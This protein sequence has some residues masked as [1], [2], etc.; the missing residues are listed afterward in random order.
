M[1]N[2]NTNQP[3]YNPS[4]IQMQPNFASGTGMF[5]NQP[6]NMT[7]MAPPKKPKSSTTSRIPSLFLPAILLLAFTWILHTLA[8]F[9]PY[10]ST[11]SQISGSRAGLWSAQNFN[12]TSIQNF[13]FPEPNTFQNITG[14][15]RFTSANTKGYL[16]TVQFLM[17][18]NFCLMFI[19]LVLLIA[20]YILSRNSTGESRSFLI[21]D[22]NTHDTVI[23]YGL[24]LYIIYVFGVFEF[25]AWITFVG[26][27]HDNNWNLNVSFAFAIIVSVF[28]IFIFIMYVIEFIKRFKK[29][30][31]T[32]AYWYGPYI[33]WGFFVYLSALLL[34]LL[35][36]CCPEWAYKKYYPLEVFAEIG[37]F[38]QCY[39]SSIYKKSATQGY[40]TLSNSQSNQSWVNAA[41]AFM[42]MA[43]I[44][45]M[46]IL[47]VI[48]I[49][50]KEFRHQENGYFAERVKQPT[51]T[52]IIAGLI[53]FFCFIFSL[54]G[55]SVFG[56]EVF[57]H[58]INVNWAYVVAVFAMV[59]FLITGILFILDGVH[60]KKQIPKVNSSP[61]RKFFL[62]APLNY[63]V[64]DI[65]PVPLPAP[66]GKSKSKSKSK[67]KPPEPLQFTHI[68][69]SSWQS[70]SPV[71]PA[72]S[73]QFGQIPPSSWQTMS[74][75]DFQQQTMYPTSDFANTPYISPQEMSMMSPNYNM[76][77][78]PSAPLTQALLVEYYRQMQ[79]NP[80]LSSLPY[81]EGFMNYSY[82]PLTFSNDGNYLSDEDRLNEMIVQHSLQQQRLTENHDRLL[83]RY[84][85][86]MPPRRSAF[87][88]STLP[89]RN[90]DEY[91][92]R[93]YGNDY[94]NTSAAMSRAGIGSSDETYRWMGD[95]YDDTFPRD[96][97]A[98]M[99]Y[100]R[101]ESMPYV[102]AEKVEPVKMYDHPMFRSTLAYIR[103]LY[104]KIR[105]SKKNN[106]ENEVKSNNVDH[107]EQT[108][109]QPTTT[110]DNNNEISDEAALEYKLNKKW[111]TKHE[112]LAPINSHL[113]NIY[114]QRLNG[115]IESYGQSLYLP[116]AHR[117]RDTRSN[118]D[119]VIFIA[120]LSDTD[121][122]GVN[123]H[124][125]A[126]E[127]ADLNLSSSDG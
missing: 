90:Y 64:L 32:W 50:R 84:S 67:V 125:T 124:A 48:V 86:A 111:T 20:D 59:L 5:M 126:D 78:Y 47:V 65:K 45:G 9:L 104:N 120:P 37:L 66:V 19:V 15:I 39:L 77:Q 103:S 41:Q 29:N 99:Q 106:D 63:R 43:Y 88:T 8:T 53:L 108:K 40:C 69:P 27:R 7:S 10:W 58:P 60:S 51:F 35:V 4:A 113:F 11:Y 101:N 57:R 89:G 30:R 81:N 14:S 71:T 34:L 22:Y 25:A 49:F 54:I 75:Y 33:E 105:Y 94:Q 68:G 3:F 119:E 36:I 70:M 61:I 110:I 62:P 97:S 87:G 42:L 116:S 100:N 121:L 93:M 127:D 114:I 76:E 56:G 80:Q 92:H 112:Y 109:T 17:T 1:I 85:G 31:V 16:V 13:Y 2:I 122:V 115:S 38:K 46:I 73:L 95:E 82:D 96:V 55:V 98:V 6:I 23:R 21:R 118:Y 117:N 107:K 24:L 123:V 18:F 83:E 72:G 28:L 26:S 102:Y 12:Y 44:I 52:Y 91:L 74:P 79:H